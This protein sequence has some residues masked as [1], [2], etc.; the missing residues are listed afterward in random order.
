MDQESEDG[1]KIVEGKGGN[2]SKRER[3][4]HGAKRV[5]RVEEEGY[6]LSERTLLEK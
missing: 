6:R 2:E 5:T 3:C 4:R 1:T